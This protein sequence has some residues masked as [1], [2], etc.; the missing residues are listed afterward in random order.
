MTGRRLA[1][2]LQTPHVWPGQ[3]HLQARWPS[4]AWAA[5]GGFHARSPPAVVTGAALGVSSTAKLSSS[6]SVLAIVSPVR[7]TVC[8]TPEAQ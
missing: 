6:S 4:G 7:D 3:W 8:A 2:R 1:H 5:F